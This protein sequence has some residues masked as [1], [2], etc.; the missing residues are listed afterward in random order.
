MQM[1][2]KR[3]P[4]FF[5]GMVQR[6][7]NFYGRQAE[8]QRIFGLLGGAQP[9]SVSVVGP[10]RIGKSSLLWYICQEGPGKLGKEW[11]FGYVGLDGLGNLTVPRLL[12]AMAA[13]LKERLSEDSYEGF[14]ALVDSLVEQKQHLVLCLDEFEAAGQLGSD[15]LGYLR[16]L[17]STN[18]A[19][20]VVATERP[21]EELSQEGV[22]TS[23]FYNIF[24]RMVLGPMPEAEARE[25][26]TQRGTMPFSS[27]E[28]ATALCQAGGSPFLLQQLGSQLYEKHYGGAGAPL[29]SPPLT[30]P[31]VPPPEPPAMPPASQ[32]AAGQEPPPSRRFQP[33]YSMTWALVGYSGALAA[34][35]LAILL[36]SPVNLIGYGVSAVLTILAF[37]ATL[38]YL[39]GARSSATP[40]GGRP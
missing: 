27:D 17:I 33:S 4:F 28:V 16:G 23:P 26:L 7:E 24:T 3:N 15:F 25:L 18:K 37:L 6:P 35:A 32:P 14:S 40:K 34:L 11:R 38:E 13:A 22:L 10:R 5:S 36:P 21:L 2:E 31:S 39:F 29:V 19:A 8:L 9:M 20:L 1:E 30:M 12:R